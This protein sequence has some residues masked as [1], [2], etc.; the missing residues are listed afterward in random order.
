MKLVLLFAAFGLACC[1]SSPS[2]EPTSPIPSEVSDDGVRAPSST[3]VSGFA[4]GLICR[5]I[6][7]RYG[8]DMRAQAD[9]P[10]WLSCREEAYFAQN[11]DKFLVNT[12]G[13]GGTLRCKARLENGPA[14]SPAVRDLDCRM[15]HTK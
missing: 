15:M 8:S 7:D 12:A 14:H 6:E 1:A 3:E 11:D 4:K 13:N 9:R 10:K 5:A 2:L